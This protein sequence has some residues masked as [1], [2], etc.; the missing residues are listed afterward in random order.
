MYSANPFSM[1]LLRVMYIF[2]HLFKTK[3]VKK[4]LTITRLMLLFALIRSSRVIIITR[5]FEVPL[6]FAVINGYDIAIPSLASAYNGPA[7][8]FF[9]F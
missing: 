4:I 7:K 2:I 6:F 1:L 9:F 5:N 3:I 8:C